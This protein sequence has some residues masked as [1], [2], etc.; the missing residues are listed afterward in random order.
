MIEHPPA[1]G[2]I[3]LIDDDPG[4]QALMQV[5]LERAGH[6]FAAAG[7]ADAGAIALESFQP[8]L[9]LL[10]YALPRIDGIEFCR[11]LRA[12]P[13]FVM[14]PVILLTGHTSLEITR[15]AVAAGVND[16]MNKSV[17]APLMLLRISASLRMKRLADLAQHRFEEIEYLASIGSRLDKSIFFDE[18]AEAAADVVE[19]FGPAYLFLLEVPS[20]GPPSLHVFGAQIPNA[21]SASVRRLVEDARQAFGATID[22]DEL[23]IF[24]TARPWATPTVALQVSYTPARDSDLRTYVAVEPSTP[25]DEESTRLLRAAIE[26]ILH[27]LQNARLYRRKQRANEELSA[28]FKALARAQAERVSAERMATVGQL[29]A[30]VAHEI[31]N[32]LAFVIS[33][34]NVLR[35]YVEDLRRLLTLFMNGQTEEATAEAERIDPEFLLDDLGPLIDETL[36]GG[37]RVHEI[38]RELRG[39]TQL[40][41]AEEFHE[42]NLQSV[43]ESVLNFRHKELKKQLFIE[44]E[45]NPVPVIRGDRG[46]LSQVFLNLVRNAARTTPDDRAGRLVVRLYA[47]DGEVAVEFEDNGIG[48]PDDVQRHVFDPFEA[49]QD[50]LIVGGLDLAIADEI[51]RRHGGRIERKSIENVGSTYTVM[52]PG[53]NTAPIP[54]VTVVP[55]PSETT[56][57]GVALFIDDERYLLNAYR[58]AFNRTVDVHTAHGGEE[59]IELLRRLERID[60]V[61]CDLV[62]PRMS[63]LDVYSWIA[64]NRRD[65]LERFVIITGGQH[66]PRNRDFLERTGLPVVHKPFRVKEVSQLLDRYIALEPR[67]FE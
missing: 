14:L 65:L 31:N 22:V 12:R 44:R 62:M 8:D 35:E 41:A 61:L 33:N 5:H 30:G 39:F 66:G 20:G 24:H 55:A 27:P 64:Q 9:V 56:V 1:P 26:R 36:E 48:L 40:E 51:V 21:H 4:Y 53:R 23:R 42:V 63:G 25:L 60:V 29:A 37:T 52:L 32:P 47:V 59:G 58:R 50:F 34:L 7:D 15:D 6:L 46:K 43:L 38:V 11:R 67:S 17:A 54:I 16:F 2:R 28:A 57:R 49:N 13:E 10:D 3:L 19:R 18:V 45:L